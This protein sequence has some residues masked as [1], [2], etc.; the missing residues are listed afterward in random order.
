M[1]RENLSITINDFD[2]EEFKTYLY[3]RE[4]SNA[5]IEK[6]MT[7]VR[8]FYNF[9]NG[10][11]TVN[12]KCLVAYKDWL[13]EHYAITSANSMIAALNQFLLFMEAGA[14]RIKRL[15]IQR[16]LFAQQEKELN[17]EEYQRLINAAKAKGKPELALII[18]TICSTGIRIS[19]LH[20]FTVENVKQGRIRVQNKGKNRVILIPAALKMKL[21]YFSQKQQR[22][23]G[24]IFV[25]RTGRSR[26]R[27]NIWSDMK[28]LHQTA[29]VD[30][31][32]IFP[33]NLRH[34][35]ARVYYAA[36]KDFVGLADLLGHSSLEVTRIYTATASDTYQQR[37]EGLMLV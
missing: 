30:A 3:E 6:Y 1:R 4:N 23:K 32:K 19:E 20:Y 35:F 16:Q 26:N 27:S 33:H 9:L 37:I 21:L 14:L 18:E 36:T 11:Q 12:K 22:T 8:T 29:G 28:A 34:L 25:T 31:I 15:K 7:D 5:T 10:S 24:C 2:L 17:R 13:V